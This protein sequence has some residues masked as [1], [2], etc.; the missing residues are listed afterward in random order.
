MLSLRSY[1][2]SDRARQ[3]PG[4]LVIDTPP[5][6]FATFQMDPEFQ[7]TRETI[8]LAL[9]EHLIRIYEN[10]EIIIADNTKFIPDI[11][12]IADRRNL[13]L[14]TKQEGDGRY[15]FLFETKDD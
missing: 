6:G 4:L 9:Y 12:A 11:N 1:L 7:E 15:G 2:A 5:L 13:I 3:N 8:P 14:F 10:R